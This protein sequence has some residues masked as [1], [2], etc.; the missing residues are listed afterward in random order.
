M[1]TQEIEQTPRAAL[2][3][4]IKVALSRQDLDK[5]AEFKKQLKL[6]EPEKSIVETPVTQTE[7]SPVEEKT[8]TERLAEAPV[9][10]TPIKNTVAR[11]KVG[12]GRPKT[13][14]HFEFPI[15]Q[16]FTVKSLMELWKTNQPLANNTVNEA[17][18]SG[19]IKLVRS[20]SHGAGRPQRIF[21]KK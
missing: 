11:V 6:L 1:E 19:L 20:E 16:E 4:N 18:K 12:R 17:S 13:E 9:V 15:N 21:V 3:H 7:V 2:V 8:I 5:V 14:R 10:V